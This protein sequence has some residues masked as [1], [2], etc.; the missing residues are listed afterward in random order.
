MDAYS[1]HVNNMEGVSFILDL[2]FF[3]GSFERVSEGEV[4]ISVG[5]KR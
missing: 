1:F 2:G 4:F 5:R 3:C